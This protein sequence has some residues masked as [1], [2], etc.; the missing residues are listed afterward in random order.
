MQGRA[1]E[2]WQHSGKSEGNVVTCR[3][4]QRKCGNMQERAK[5]MW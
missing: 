4:E 2:M 1:K 3:E 5:E